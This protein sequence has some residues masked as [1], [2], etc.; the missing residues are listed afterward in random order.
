MIAWRQVLQLNGGRHP[1]KRIFEGLQI[2]ERE[3]TYLFT[4]KSYSNV[5]LCMFLVCL[6]IISK[7]D[8][9]QNSEAKRLVQIHRQLLLKL[10][11]KEFSK[12]SCP[13]GMMRAYFLASNYVVTA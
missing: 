10:I 13:F 4:Y 3:I 6:Y 9:L 5:I 7:M 12:V 2:V 1:I 11:F 8:Y